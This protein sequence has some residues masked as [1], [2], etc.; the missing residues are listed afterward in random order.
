MRTENETCCAHVD[1]SLICDCIFMLA[2]QQH[3]YTRAS[4][5]SQAQVSMRS[6]TGE[7]SPRDVANRAMGILLNTRREKQHVFELGTTVHLVINMKQGGRVHGLTKTSRYLP[8]EQRRSQ[9]GWRVG[10]A[11][12]NVRFTETSYWP[13]CKQSLLCSRC[14][15]NGAVATTT[16]PEIV[17]T[18]DGSDRIEK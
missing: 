4:I 18:T 14:F 13:P 8:W 2:S 16:A 9:C 12:A 11:V 6:V 1:I 17:T 15:C 5:T 7:Y 3:I 10:S